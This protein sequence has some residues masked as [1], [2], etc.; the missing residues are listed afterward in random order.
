MSVEL[1]PMNWDAR[2]GRESPDKIRSQVHKNW[3]R[4]HLCLAWKF[5]DCN[6][7]IEAAHCRDVAPRGHGGGKPSD[8]WCA[9]FC[10]KHHGEAEK[11]EKA[12]GDE[13]GIDVAA[14]C[15]G[16]AAQSPDRRIRDAAKLM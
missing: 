12:W 1:P 5:Q 8:S 13:N 16:L 15:K 14:Q 7:P 4:K 11:R 9:P 10:R 2:S 6:G 3:I